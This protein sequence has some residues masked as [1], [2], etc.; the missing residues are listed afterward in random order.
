MTTG[1]TPQAAMIS[2]SLALKPL[3]DWCAGSNAVNIALMKWRTGNTWAICASTEVSGTGK[4]VPE[5]N[6]IG[7]KTPLTI[8]GAASALGMT[9]VMAI[10]SAQNDSAPTATATAAARMCAGMWM[11]YTVMP[12]TV[13]ITV[14]TMLTMTDD[15]TTPAMKAQGGNGVP[16]RRLRMPV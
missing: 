16:R 6:T 10:P 8:A 11:P 1:P 14:S 4:N 5:M 2:K 3:A 9:M 15:P 12:N 13:V 7:R